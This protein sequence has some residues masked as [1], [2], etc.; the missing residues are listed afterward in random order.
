MRVGCSKPKQCPFLSTGYGGC[1][2]TNGQWYM[3]PPD[4]DFADWPDGSLVAF[5]FQFGSMHAALIYH[6]LSFFL[7]LADCSW[8]SDDMRPYFARVESALER[9][10]SEGSI[11]GCSPTNAGLC[12]FPQARFLSNEM[13]T[14]LGNAEKLCICCC[15][16]LSMLSS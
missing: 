14:A 2:A 10:S 12:S 11:A 5:Q 4:R 13:F 7:V 15:W 8:Q 1:S 6:H 3:V 9:V 16:V